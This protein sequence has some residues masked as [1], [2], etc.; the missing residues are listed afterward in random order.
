VAEKE[1]RVGDVVVGTCSWTDKTMIERWYPRGV[2]TPEARLRYYAARYDTVEVDSTFYGLPREDYARHWAERTPENFTFH[3]KAYGLMTGHE[4]DERS[5]TPELREFEYEVTRTGRV[6]NPDERMVVLSSE[7]F[8]D[9]LQPLIAAEKMG[10]V[11]LQ[12]PSYVT[13]VDREHER[14]NLERIDRAAAILDPLPVFVEFRHSSWVTG[15][16]LGRTMRFLADRNLTYVAVDAPQLLG[17]HTMPPVSAATSNLGYVRFHGRNKSMWNA[18]TASAAD[19][20]DYLYD[21]HEL[22][23]WGPS[24]VDLAGSTDRTWVMFNNCKYDYAPRNAREM[25]EILGDVVAP[26][27]GGTPTGEPLAPEG[28]SGPAA[29]QGADDKFATGQLF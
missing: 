4:V 6:R 7:L 21:P 10:G 17:G 14:R 23:E 25:A 2:S 28:G 18:R 12:Y 27:A 1:V 11:L 3:V 5:L 29:R 16:Q 9:A 19:R 15:R 20:F 22:A 26:R 24:I 8:L 13:A